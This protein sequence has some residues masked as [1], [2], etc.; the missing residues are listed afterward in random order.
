MKS[1]RK[2]HPAKEQNALSSALQEQA[3]REFLMDHL[4]LAPFL[5]RQLRVM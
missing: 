5:I 2:M 1:I 4:F 3:S